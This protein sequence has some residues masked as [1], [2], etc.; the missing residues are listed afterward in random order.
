MSVFYNDK[1]DLLYLRLDDGKQTG[2]FERGGDYE[3]VLLL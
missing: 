1:A 2:K 3:K